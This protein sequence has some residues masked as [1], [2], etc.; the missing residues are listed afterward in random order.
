MSVSSWFRSQRSRIEGKR[1]V[2][3]RKAPPQRPKRLRLALELL[4]DRTVPTS[5]FLDPTFGSLPTL[6][7]RVVTDFAGGADE[8]LSLALQSDHKIVAAGTASG[9]GFA[10]A[11]YNLNGS[12]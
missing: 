4:E 12:L 8:V 5:G 1:H 2:A 9:G 6:P 3:P 7:G 11:R 10:L